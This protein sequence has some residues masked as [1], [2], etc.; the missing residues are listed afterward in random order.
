MVW[1]ALLDFLYPPLCLICDR[2]LGAA[3]RLVCESCWDRARREETAPFYV[4]PGGIGGSPGEG[5]FYARSANRWNDTLGLILHRF[6]YGGFPSLGERLARSLLSVVREDPFLAE[7]DLVVPVPLT[8]ARL[9][10][11]GFNQ[12][13]LLA[14]SLSAS[15]GAPMAERAVR[16]VGRSHSQTRLGPEGRRRNVRRAFLPRDPE[17]V[18]GA[19][20]LVVDDVITTGSTAYALARVLAGAGARSVS[21]LSVARA[22]GASSSRRRPSSRSSSAPLPPPPSKR[23][24][25]LSI[26]GWFSPPSG[27]GL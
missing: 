7:A 18:R 12:S 19:K 24:T 9:A 20:V 22:G 27:W 17:A 1:E 6:K 15:S 25:F 14:R 5:L 21:I 4:G 11:R 10:E 8:R 26:T 3:E 16:R 23:R 13:L 2:R